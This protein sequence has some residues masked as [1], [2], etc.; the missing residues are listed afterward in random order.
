MLPPNLVTISWISLCE[1]HT[2][3]QT[4]LVMLDKI[5]RLLLPVQLLLHPHLHRR[6]PLLIGQN[7]SAADTRLQWVLGAHD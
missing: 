5:L 1:R 6:L 2:T 7:A 4:N 3:K